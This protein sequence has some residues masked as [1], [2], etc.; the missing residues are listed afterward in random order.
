MLTRRT[1]ISIE[2]E[3]RGLAAAPAV[4]RVMGETLGWSEQDIERELWHY[5]ARVDAERDAQR[6]P[7]ITPPTR[8]ASGR[9]MCEPG[10]VAI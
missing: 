2:A 3:D 6:S 9:P 5:H 1:R 7:T 10:R 8:P 4:A